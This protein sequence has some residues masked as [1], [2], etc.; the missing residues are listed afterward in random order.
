[1]RTRPDSSSPWGVR[2]WYDDAEFDLMM[3]ELRT[4]ARL[5]KFEPGRGIDV[6]QILLDVY[7]VSPDFGETDERTLGRST[8]HT[9]GRLE[10]S[11]SRT[12]SDAAESDH[13]A[14]RRLR[15]TLAHECAHIVLHQHLHV[16]PA[17]GYLFEPPVS[18]PKVLCRSATIDRLQ[19]VDWWEFQANRGMACL[20]LPKALL[21][22][23][24]REAIKALG[25]TDVR[26]LL[27]AG[28]SEL[29]VRQLMNEFDVGM[30]MTIYRLQDLGFFQ[31]N[32]DQKELT[33]G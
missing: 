7:N 32:G 3:D 11:V 16:A 4:R 28:Q 6:E 25:A 18:A 27:R 26:E 1:M 2:V 21:T 17:T 19:G 29:L 5:S 24:V 10:V 23:S 33:L 22:A 8:F 9:D 30:E 12:L 31:R 20:L 15:S 13:V 14:R